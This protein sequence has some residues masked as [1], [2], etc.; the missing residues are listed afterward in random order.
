MAT[1][2]DVFRLMMRDEIAPRLRRMGFKGSGQSF[3]LPS[4]SHWV[5]VGFQKS[6]YSNADAVRFTINV[7]VV[8]KRRWR[9]A[10]G[11]H[12]YLSDRPSANISYGGFAWQRRIGQLVP[13]V[14]DKWWTVWTGRPTGSVSA[15]VLDAI[16]VY[17]VPAIDRQLASEP[18]EG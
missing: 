18:G 13:D 10:Q 6:T 3:T 11:E 12:S 8:S 2:L 15:E 4:E 17:A 1:A 16:R 7:T 14:G 5:L 9:E